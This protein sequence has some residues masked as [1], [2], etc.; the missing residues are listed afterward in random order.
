MAT[1]FLQISLKNFMLILISFLF[2]KIYYR[3]YGAY[4]LSI[5]ICAAQLIMEST[6]CSALKLLPPLATAFCMPTGNV[7]YVFESVNCVKEW[8]KIFADIISGKISTFASPCILAFG[9]F[10]LAEFGLMAA[11]NWYSASIK[12]SGAFSLAIFAAFLILSKTGCSPEPFV[13]CDKKAT[14]GFKPKA[15]AN[16]A[17]LTA[18][19][20]NSSAL[21][22]MTKSLSEQ[23]NILFFMA[24][25]NKP[26]T[27]IT[28]SFL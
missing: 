23:T 13:E 5:L 22:A 18:I 27:H 11:S 2:F 24:R 4:L 15:F 25:I 3:Q 8:A 7:P 21:G 6:I 16:P 19:C 14:L 20:A 10:L 17:A 28:P 1:S 26:E 9:H 12:N